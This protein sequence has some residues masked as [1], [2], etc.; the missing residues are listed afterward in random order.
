MTLAEIADHVC[1]IVGTTDADSVTLCK[2]FVQRRY[3]LIWDA[4]P[5]RE[6]LDVITQTAD[7]D[8]RDQVFRKGAN[9]E[10]IL[11]IGWDDLITLEPVEWTNLLLQDSA[12]FTATG[13][14]VGQFTLRRHTPVWHGVD[15]LETNGASGLSV[16]VTNLNTA[17]PVTITI[18][19]PRFYGLGYAEQ[20]S[21]VID[22]TSEFSIPLSRF[23]EI[24]RITLSTTGFASGNDLEL[25][26]TGGTWTDFFVTPDTIT[27]APVYPQVR[28]SKKA[29]SARTMRALGKLRVQTLADGDTPLLPNVTEALINFAQ[30]D[31]LERQRQYSK[32]QVKKTEG[33]GLVQMLVDLQ[34]RQTADGSQIIPAIEPDPYGLAGQQSKGYW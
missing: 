21:Q 9:I 4:H 8:Y 10:R 14:S 26:T 19:G 7:S 18:Y 32:A 20:V 17:T 13:G 3:S 22:T 29:D 11:A 6:T 2:T 33:A 24:T 5:W 16:R 15:W 34:R 27:E 28:L 1:E 12:A 23:R 25:G 30:A 31:M